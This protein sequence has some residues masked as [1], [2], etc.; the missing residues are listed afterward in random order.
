MTTADPQDDRTAATYGHPVPLIKATGPA[1]AAAFAERILGKY[2]VAPVIRRG[3]SLVLRMLQSAGIAGGPGT[4]KKVPTALAAVNGAPARPAVRL[5]TDVGRQSVMPSHGRLATWTPDWSRP[6][7]VYTPRLLV[8]RKPLVIAPASLAPAAMTAVAPCA[9]GV[10]L[11]M[12]HQA[13][14]T[15]IAL[16]GADRAKIPADTV[17]TVADPGMVVR[18]PTTSAGLSPVVDPRQVT[19]TAFRSTTPE[20]ILASSTATTQGAPPTMPDPAAGRLPRPAASPVART[21]TPPYAASHPGSGLLRQVSLAGGHRLVQRQSLALPRLGTPVAAAIGRSFG[22]QSFGA[23]PSAAAPE[24]N[25]PAASPLS[26]G[27]Q[28][29]ASPFG[30]APKRFFDP[31]PPGEPV[32]RASRAPAPTASVVARTGTPPYTASRPGSGL[33]RQV[34]LAGGHRLVQRKSLALPRLGTP[35]AAAIGRSFGGQSFGAMPSAAAPEHNYPAASPLS[36]GYQPA[37]SPFGRAPKRFFDPGP[38]GE[39]V[40]RASRAP[41]PTAS[42]VARTGT[43]PYTASRPGSGLLRQVAL[44]DGHRLVQ[45]KSLALPSLATPVTAAMGRSFGGH[46]FGVKPS[47]AAPE[48]HYPAASPRPSGYQPAAPTFGRASERFFDPGPPGDPVPRATGAQ[49]PT[50]SPVARTGTPPYAASRPGSGLLRRVAVAGGHRLVQRKSLVLPTFDTP[51]AAAMGRSFGGQSFGVK[52]SAPAREHNYPVASA[53]TATSIS[54]GTRQLTSTLPLTTS[55]AGRGAS[56]DGRSTPDRWHP[57]RAPITLRQ[58]LDRPLPAGLE[59]RHDAGDALQAPDMTYL[60]DGQ[61]AA[62][63]A[64]GAQ[65]IATELTLRT[66]LAEVNPHPT[67]VAATLSAATP[68]PT[69]P[70]THQDLH[71]R[72]EANA[73]SMSI[74]F[75]AD[76]IFSILERRLVVERERRGIRS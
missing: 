17:T 24:H 42:V 76:R 37:A 72:Q 46:S 29:A 63:P 57:A 34:A 53:I 2:F 7:P 75:L 16:P 40:P 65:P 67:L 12:T 54:D 5:A 56:P 49:A 48:H 52:P 3:P 36:S 69:A 25:Y 15:A 60:V 70:A 22:G 28:P 6:A 68:T 58:V 10:A 74:E 45:R 66:P 19:A 47:A 4:G 33:L 30:R 23:M 71:T 59:R 27:Y 50:A 35:V 43:P 44:A 41:A 1:A 11:T 26:S 55:A 13:T 9:L 18:R 39:P 73:S 31:G 62:H 38:P 32:P 64:A 51:V 21:G 61:A 20:R 14:A 8:Q